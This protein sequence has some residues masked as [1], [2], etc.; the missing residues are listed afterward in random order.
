MPRLG[1]GRGVGGMLSEPLLV[2]AGGARAG[3]A[4]DIPGFRGRAE[5]IVEE[6]VGF[7][8]HD[9]RLHTHMHNDDAQDARA[10]DTSAKRK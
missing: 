4:A 7:Q 3:F 5:P 9:G 2:V 6:P 1:G 10:C 8:I